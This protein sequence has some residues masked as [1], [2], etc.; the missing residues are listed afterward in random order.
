MLNILQTVALVSK[1]LETNTYFSF[2]TI[3]LFSVSVVGIHIKGG[4]TLKCHY[5]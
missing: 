1:I 4:M 3:L 2:K 5:S